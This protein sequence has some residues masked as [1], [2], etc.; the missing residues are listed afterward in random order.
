MLVQHGG[1]ISMVFCQHGSTS[2][3]CVETKLQ[4]AVRSS[5]EKQ[6][7]QLKTDIKKPIVALAAHPSERLGLLALHADGVLSCFACNIQMRSMTVRWAAEVWV[8]KAMIAQVQEFEDILD[9]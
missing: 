8:T 7:G 2:V 9:W 1:G 6:G 3:R 5:K 4:S